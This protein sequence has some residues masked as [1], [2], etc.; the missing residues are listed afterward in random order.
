VE[1]CVLSSS[2]AQFAKLLRQHAKVHHQQRISKQLEALPVTELPRQA[3]EKRQ[4]LLDAN[5]QH[6]LALIKNYHARRAILTG[7]SFNDDLFDLLWEHTQSA[8]REG[9][10]LFPPPDGQMVLDLQFALTFA[11]EFG[12]MAIEASV[13]RVVARRLETII[14]DPTAPPGLREQSQVFLRELFERMIPPIEPTESSWT[15]LTLHDLHRRQQLLCWYEFEHERLVEILR[16][17]WKNPAARLLRLREAYPQA[18]YPKV[19]DK[20]LRAWKPQ[21]CS[22]IA[23]KLVGDRFGLEAETVRRYLPQARKERQLF[24]THKGK[25]ER[26]R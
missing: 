20:D 13:V 15:A 5:T 17:Q 9:P 12:T 24:F 1:V 10:P 6:I 25:S 4:K 14:Q 7:T 26:T 23:H 8:P 22:R 18:Q 2:F 21:D 3:D 19:S 11:L 16:Q